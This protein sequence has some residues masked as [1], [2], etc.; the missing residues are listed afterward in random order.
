MTPH[1]KT[2]IGQAVAG[3]LFAHFI[4][5]LA[6]F[7]VGN[8]I[9]W[10]Q[11]T[12][13]LAVLTFF[14][15]MGLAAGVPAGMII[16]ACTRSDA[17]PL[18]WILRSVVALLVLLPGWLFFRLIAY[19]TTTKEQLWLLAWLLLPAVMIGLLTHSRL[20]VGRELIRGGEAVGRVSRVLAGFTGVILRMTVVFL[21]MECLLAAVYLQQS[22]S[23]QQEIIWTTLLC[24]H[25][26]TSL[27]VMFLR[28]DAGWRAMV[29]AIALAPLIIALF[30]FPEMTEMLRYVFIAYLTLWALFLLSR[31]RQT[32]VALAFL[33]EEIHYY[34]ID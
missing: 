3:S 11:A 32:D 8:D 9:N 34:L 16:W 5:F 20:R 29:S 21:F 22:E 17:Q 13:M 15:I 10:G 2:F 33:N 1:I 26:T 18:H 25:F 28:T 30:T 23:R 24:G 12:E 4:L 14:L 6:P 19:T 31:W 27:L 7:L